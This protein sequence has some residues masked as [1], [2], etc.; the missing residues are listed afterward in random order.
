MCTALRIALVLVAGLYLAGLTQAQ[1][2]SSQQIK[3][4]QKERPAESMN[5]CCLGQYSIRTE[6]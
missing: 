4:T 5:Q 1:E 3:I 2:H 6:P